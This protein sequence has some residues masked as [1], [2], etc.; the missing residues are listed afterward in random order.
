VTTRVVVGDDDVLLREGLVRLLDRQRGFEVVGVAADG[1]DI[2]RKTRAHRPDLV[3]ADIRM[4]PTNTDDGLQAALTIRREMPD[5]G[6]LVLSQYVQE[7]YAVELLGDDPS[8]VGYLLKQRI[9]DLDLFFEALRRILAG[10]SVVDPEVISSMLAP[11]GE[12]PLQR[13]TG[14]QREVLALMAEGRSNAGI[15]EALVVNEKAV[16]KH[17][18]K[19]FEVL[20]LD[21]A[22]EGHRRVLAVIA[23]LSDAG[24]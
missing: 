17:I 21:P 13:L 5:V 15:A 12:Q 4:P 7:R 9:A 8:G 18:T 6:V 11:R 24:R 2:V 20:G 1:P 3:I 16:T 10:G 23:F 19:I 22:A 14:R